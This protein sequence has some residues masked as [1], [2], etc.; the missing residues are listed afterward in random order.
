M[1]IGI[2]ARLYGLEHTGIG[3]YIMEL[4]EQL[5]QLDLKHEFIF[6]VRP[7]HE[8]DIPKHPKF[9]S[10]VTDI[11]H[12][13]F[14]EQLE[15]PSIFHAQKLD[16]IHIPHFNVPFLLRTPFLVT[17]HDLLWHE[18]TGYTVTTLDPL[19]YF[20]KYLGY[21]FIVNHAVKHAKTII[22]PSN[23]VKNQ[24]VTRF[25]VNPV[26][27][28]V[29]HEGVGSTF[30]KSNPT[31]PSKNGIIINK[32]FFVYTGSLYPHK[33]VGVVIRALKEINKTAEKKISLVLVSSR[34]IFTEPTRKL[35]YD[36]DQEK[37]VKFVGFLTDEELH[38]IYQNAIGLVHPSLS[39]GF[40]LTG[41][42][43]MAS[44]LPVIAS[45]AGSLP[46]IYEEAA[47]YFNP[48]KPKGLAQKMLSLLQNPKL[49]KN[50]IQS[51]F[52]QVKKYSWAKMAQ[53][54]LAV[55]DSALPTR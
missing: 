55:Y 43:A 45:T 50:L 27:I 11:R 34:S 16:L 36:L 35:A 49:R 25:H 28:A 47:L 23:T 26:K 31:F 12:Y 2:D 39:E 51:G 52:S 48:H 17:I 1:R 14:K 15:L 54:T 5:S 7:E 22:A 9:T 30:R 37:Y 21:R 38:T 46:E 10:I 41:L 13:T 40:G 29:T 24:I 42:E 20:I 3:R 53:Q 18:V 32:P 6:F 8:M 4:I 33:N 44:G 19:S